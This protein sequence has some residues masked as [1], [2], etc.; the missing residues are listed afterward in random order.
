[1]KIAVV[2]LNW[3]GRG[4]LERFLPSVVEYTQVEAEVIVA[5]NGSTD[6]SLQFLKE[7]YP[8]IRVIAMDKNYGFAG[9][10]NKALEQVEADYFV[11]LNDDVEVSPH[12]VKNVVSAMEMDTETAIGQPKILMYDDKN[13]FEYA[14]AAGGWIDSYGYPFCRGRMFDIV[15]EDNG[16]YDQECECFWATGAAMFVKA[17][18]WKELKGLDEDFFAHMEEIDLCWRAQNAGWK[19]K[20]YPQSKV[21]HVGGGTLPKSSPTKTYLNFRNNLYM[22]YKNLPQKRMKRVLA[23]RMILDGVAAL[24]FLTEGKK[25]EFTAVWRAHKDYRKHKKELGFKR[26]NLPQKE[27]DTIYQ[28]W[29]LVDYYMRKKTCFSQLSLETGKMTENNNYNNK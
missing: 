25:D 9:G 5:D 29:L 19:V 16:Q 10:Y 20:C 7:N 12:W 6:D 18:V 8:Q 4:M 15:E 28:G 26:A 2:I 1:M 13:R 23:A 27:I 3:N 17:A 14:G 11:L 24:K 22:L 21:W